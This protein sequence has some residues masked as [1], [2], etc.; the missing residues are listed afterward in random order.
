M[1]KT[2]Y[3]Y[4]NKDQ[5]LKCEMIAKPIMSNEE[6]KRKNEEYASLKKEYS[7]FLKKSKTIVV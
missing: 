7:E 4:D 6:L 3:S 5:E 1:S 2:F